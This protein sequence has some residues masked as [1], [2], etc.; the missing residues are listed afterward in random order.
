MISCRIVFFEAK[1]SYHP[2][3]YKFYKSRVIN[4]TL[5]YNCIQLHVSSSVFKR[6]ILKRKFFNEKI[7]FSEDTR[8]INNILLFHPIM[9]ILKEAIFY[10]RRRNDFSS[11]IQNRDNNFNFYFETI[12]SVFYYFLNTSLVLYNTIV[13]FI[14][15][16]V[17]YELLFRIQSRAYNILDSDNLKKYIFLIEEI[18]KKIEDKYILEQNILSNKYK[19]FILSKKYQKDIRFHSKLIND[20][21]I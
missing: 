4:L 18:L 12:N 15:F 3:D 17:G 8:F 11:L 1:T 20:S 13:S 21:I 19:F 6:Y 7:S 9:G 2:L 16:L 5:D 14:Q 10:Y